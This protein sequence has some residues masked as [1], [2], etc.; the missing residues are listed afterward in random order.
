MK[1]LIATEDLEVREE[2]TLA[3][4]QSVIQ[5]A[6]NQSALSVATVARRMGVDPG[7]VLHML[8]G[9]YRLTVKEL[10]R[11][12]A[13]CGFEVHFRLKRAKR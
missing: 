6:L 11:I 10:G 7:S 5:N 3:M 8:R 2:S 9:D 13:A 1:L 4:A 12:V